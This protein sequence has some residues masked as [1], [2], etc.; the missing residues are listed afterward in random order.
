MQPEMTSGNTT[1][2]YHICM[3]GYLG[4]LLHPQ[5]GQLA[6]QNVSESTKRLRKLIV[7][8]MSD[9]RL[10]CETAVRRI[11]YCMLKFGPTLYKRCFSETHNTKDYTSLTE[12]ISFVAIIKGIIHH[13]P[14]D[15]M[16]GRKRIELLEGFYFELYY[17]NNLEILSQNECTSTIELHET[18]VDALTNEKL[19]NLEKISKIDSF[20]LNFLEEHQ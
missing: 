15:D 4:V 5:T 18:I 7:A 16:F 1:R 11:K 6:S 3:A 8:I 19:S 12:F 13:E 10:S 14:Q 9:N 17:P 2:E 20:M